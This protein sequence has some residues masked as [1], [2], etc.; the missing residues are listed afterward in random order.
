MEIVGDLL[1]NAYWQKLQLG[2]ELDCPDES[3]QEIT[4][5][6]SGLTC[7]YA[8]VWGGRCNFYHVR[9]LARLLISNRC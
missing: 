1:R 7:S 3:E 6:N 4:F 2:R 8:P 9:H 5:V